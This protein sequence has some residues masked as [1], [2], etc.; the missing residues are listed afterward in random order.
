MRRRKPD[1]GGRFLKAPQKIGSAS[2]GDVELK[3]LTLLWRAV[4]AQAVRDLTAFDLEAKLEAAMWL[5]SQDF[6]EVC[7]LASIDPGWLE[8]EIMEKVKMKSPYREKSLV[9]LSRT[10][11]RELWPMPGEYREGDEE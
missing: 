2:D 5:H 10:L 6:T 9:R 7:D 11:N 3:P 4:A 8:K 1:A